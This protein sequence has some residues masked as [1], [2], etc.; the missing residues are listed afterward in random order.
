LIKSYYKGIFYGTNLGHS[1][2]NDGKNQQNMATLKFLQVIDLIV[3]ICCVVDFCSGMIRNQQ[4][5]G[6]SPIASSSICSRSK[7]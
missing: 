1:A 7:A 6:S 2:A 3:I 5:A 4:V